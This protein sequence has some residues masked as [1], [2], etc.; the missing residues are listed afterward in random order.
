MKTLFIDP[1]SPWENGYIESFS[2]KLRDE[3]I[4]REVFTTLL[5]AKIL[6]EDWR[7]HNSEFRTHSSLGYRPPAPDATQLALIPATRA[8]PVVLLL[9]A[10]QRH[11]DVFERRK[12]AKNE[13]LTARMCYNTAIRRQSLEP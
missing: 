9:R 8:D 5:E 2:R 12:G 4:N 11:L 1:G 10:P 7:K 13:T 3:L 6:I